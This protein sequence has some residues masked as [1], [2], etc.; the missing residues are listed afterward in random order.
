[1]VKIEELTNKQIHD[2]INEL[3][4][5]IQSI[6][7]TIENFNEKMNAN[8]QEYE[9]KKII[10]DYIKKILKSNFKGGKKKKT[11]KKKK[12]ISKRNSKRNLV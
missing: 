11:Y 12:R 3:Y 2:K 1:M 8:T 6:K 9:T 10:R 7:K 4:E 5:H